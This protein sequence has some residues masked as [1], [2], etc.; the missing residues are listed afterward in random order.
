M[1]VDGWGSSVSETHKYGSHSAGEAF[2]SYRELQI[3]WLRVLSVP[4][5]AY[6]IELCNASHT[7]ATSRGVGGEMG[8]VA[9][10]HVCVKIIDAKGIIL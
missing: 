9:N 1:L 4:A 8:V 3:R 5:W 10:P 7:L 2:D 6:S